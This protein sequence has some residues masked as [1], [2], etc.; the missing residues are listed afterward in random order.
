[1]NILVRVSKDTQ[2]SNFIA[3]RSL[4]AELFYEDGT[5]HTPHRSYYAAMTLTSSVPPPCI[6]TEPSV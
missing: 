4:K 5:A 3:I 6:H 2:I 1:L